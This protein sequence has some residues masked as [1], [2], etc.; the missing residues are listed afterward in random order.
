MAT[1]NYMRSFMYVARLR[2]FTFAANGLGTATAS[3]SRNVSELERNLQKRLFD[4][5]LDVSH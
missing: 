5:S 2:S 1:L 4:H 3:I